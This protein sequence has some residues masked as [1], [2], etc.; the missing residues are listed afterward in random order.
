MFG[1][2]MENEMKNTQLTA[3]KLTT[4][5]IGNRPVRNGETVLVD[6]TVKSFMVTVRSINKVGCEDIK[7]LIEKKFEVV[8]IDE[9]GSTSYFTPIG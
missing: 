1:S 4:V 6:H 3:S 7:N 8:Q 2:F 5:N 9:A